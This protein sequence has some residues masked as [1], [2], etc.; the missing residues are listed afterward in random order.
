MASTALSGLILK[1]YQEPSKY[2]QLAGLQVE[3]F[4][5]LMSEDVNE[6]VLTFLE[7]LNRMGGM[8]KMVPVLDKMSLSGAEAA[9]VISTPWACFTLYMSRRTSAGTGNM[10]NAF[11]P[12][13]SMW[14]LIPTSLNGFVKARTA[15]LGFSP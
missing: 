6:A 5:K 1:L 11:K 15:L 13:S 4:T 10:R 9:S 7:A 14:V 8:D 2:A 3:E 12:R